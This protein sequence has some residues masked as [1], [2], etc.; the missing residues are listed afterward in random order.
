[1]NSKDAWDYGYWED[2]EHLSEWGQFLPEEMIPRDIVSNPALT[3]AFQR[4]SLAHS[5]DVVNHT[6]TKNPYTEEA[7]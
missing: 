3:E 6:E 7:S 5:M 1:M 4:G 2:A